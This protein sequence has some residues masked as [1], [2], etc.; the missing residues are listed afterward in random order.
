[1][2]IKLK[3]IKLKYTNMSLEKELN[4]ILELQDVSIDE[5]A[6]TANQGIFCEHW[7]TAKKVLKRL[8]LVIKNPVA[9]WVLRGAIAIGDGIH[10]RSCG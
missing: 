6:L 7:P 8:M 1:M 4:Q 3:I 9:K 2:G 10:R 5:S